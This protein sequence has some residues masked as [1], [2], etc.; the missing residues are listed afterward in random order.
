MN[1]SKSGSS[2]F[3]ETLKRWRAK[4]SPIVGVAAVGLFLYWT[5]SYGDTIL[6]TF[7]ELGG[8]QL[9]FVVVLLVV[10]MLLEVYIFVILV[11]DKKYTFSFAD[12]YHSLNLSH[13]AAM[14]PGG[15]WGYAGLAGM[16]WSKGISKLDSVLV[17]FF[18]T[19]ISLTA[20]A[21]VGFSG[22]FSIFGWGYSL[23]IFLPFIFAVVAR[24]WMD[25]LRQ[26]YY[27]ES[28]QLPSVSTLLKSLFLGMIVWVIV[29]FCFTW[30][31]NSSEGLKNIPFW[32]IFGAYAAG[33]LG[34]YITLLA[35]SGIGVSEGLI[36][37]IL[38]PYFGT[39]QVM[40]VA[41]SFRIIHSIV[42]WSN[43][44]LTVIL[45]SKQAGKN[46]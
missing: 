26:K 30:I 28:S 4:L 8:V 38:G 32:I 24:N 14:I 2:K 9:F 44:L 37:L 10:A 13:V 31:L 5:F 3:L 21:M 20:C 29:S 42:V 23:I 41:I 36:T 43:V 19:L 35:P 27:P 46:D 39:S 45:T 7:K 16:L 1:V 15:I 17:I 11:Q 34:G 12:G 33:Y 40:S 25:Q 6:S 22:L 18:Y